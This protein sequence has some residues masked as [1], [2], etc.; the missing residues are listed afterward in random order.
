MI[1]SGADLNLK[2]K[3][4]ETALPLACFGGKSDM[5]RLLIKAG[6]DVNITDE[7]G[8][9][10]LINAAMDYDF[11]HSGEISLEMLL[12]TGAKVNIMNHYGNAVQNHII[13]EHTQTGQDYQYNERT[14]K[15]L[16]AAGETKTCDSSVLRDLEYMDWN[17]SKTVYSEFLNKDFKPCLKQQCREMIRRHLLEINDVNLFNRVPKLGLPT[18]LAQYLVFNVPPPDSYYFADS[19]DPDDDCDDSDDSDDEVSDCRED[20]N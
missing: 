5:V 17:R 10:P 9:T 13:H 7:Y 18:S 15:L 1:V 14:C 3:D 2:Q 19:D 4:G 11:R 6:A 12:H 16:L 20:L 8:S